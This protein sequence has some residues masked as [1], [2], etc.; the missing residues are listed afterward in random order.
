MIVL[1]L[2]NLNLLHGTDSPVVV[3]G[4]AAPN[5]HAGLVLPAGEPQVRLGRD[6]V[7]PISQSVPKHRSLPCKHG[8]VVEGRQE[9]EE[10]SRTFPTCQCVNKLST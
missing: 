1:R 8:M 3:A 10:G 5:L 2:I 9:S 4:D 7:P 6:F